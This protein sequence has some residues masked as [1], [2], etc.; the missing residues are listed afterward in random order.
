M[1][2][3]DQDMKRKGQDLVHTEG[4][5]VYSRKLSSGVEQLRR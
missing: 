2:V 1:C 3:F 5:F 4:E